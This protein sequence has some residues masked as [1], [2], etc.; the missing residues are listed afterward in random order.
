[1]Q[2]PSPGRPR[3]CRSLRV[4]DR[5]PGSE[6]GVTS[7]ISFVELSGSSI[8]NLNA[9][10]YTIAASPGAVSKAVNVRYTVDAL[11]QRRYTVPGGSTLIVPVFG[12]YSGRVNHVSLV[13]QFADD[14]SQN[15]AV[16][17][18]SAP[19]TDPNGVYDQATILK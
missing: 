13:L 12:L 3:Q 2:H 18:T 9:V 19:Y 5:S 8:A 11:R 10:R 4:T 1:M 15:I 16:D 6:P 14:S 17:V 7:F